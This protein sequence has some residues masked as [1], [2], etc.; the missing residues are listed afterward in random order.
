VL[1]DPMKLEI[2]RFP[3]I[4][5]LVIVEVIVVS[6]VLLL[7]GVPSVPTWTDVHDNAPAPEIVDEV[8][9]VPREFNVTAPLTVTVKPEL[10]VR[11]ALAPT[12][13]KVIELHAASA[14]TVTVN[15]FSI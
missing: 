11:V 8:L 9:E 14:V 4:E 5:K 7:P 6:L 3:D 1:L 12:P 10:T 15:P 13:E 2:V